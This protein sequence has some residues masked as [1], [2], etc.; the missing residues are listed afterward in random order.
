[1]SF[2]DGDS[3]QRIVWLLGTA[4]LAAVVGC[5]GVPLES[6]P[7]ADEML[8]APTA[9]SVALTETEAEQDLSPAPEA[10]QRRP[11]LI[12]NA[13]LQLLL[14]DVDEAISAISDILRE[15]QGDLI[16]LSDQANQSNEPRQVWIELRVPQG[17]LETVLEQLQALGT[18]EQQSITAEDVSTQLVDLQARVRNLRNSE[19]ALL[20]IMDRSGSVADV[21]EVAREL[22]NVRETI[23]R[24]DAQLTNLQNQVAYSTITLTLVSNVQLT[25]PTSPIGETLGATWA[26]AIA[27]MRSLSVGMLQLVLWLLAFSPYIGILVLVSWAGR[28]YRERQRTS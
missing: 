27:S 2:F 28:R 17:N 26:T 9:D 21:L 6:S 1:M 23:E 18:V 11:Q 24:T 15:S 13:S 22:S 3:R 4:S 19:E 10:S 5:S 20:E 25:P 16:Q 12:K 8:P 14:T 7:S